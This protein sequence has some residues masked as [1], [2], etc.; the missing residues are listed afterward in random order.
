MNHS[1]ARPVPLDLTLMSE[2]QGPEVAQNSTERIRPAL[3][4]IA[5]VGVVSL[6]PGVVEPTGSHQTTFHG[7]KIG[8]VFIINNHNN[9]T[10]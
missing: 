3:C 4:R 8:V 9:N 7:V 1:R 5:L 6:A 2:V 10:G